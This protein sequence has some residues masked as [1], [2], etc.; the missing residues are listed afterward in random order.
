[1][2]GVS[3]AASLLGLGTVGCQIAI[4]LYTLASQISTAS[5]RISSVSNDIS[6]TAGVLK[7]LGE[8]MTRETAKGGESIFS[9]S[10]L[11]TTKNSAAICETIFNQIEQAAKE[12][13]DQLRTRDRII[14]KIKL[15]KSE[16]AKW[17]FLQP[18]I[19]S[20]RTDLREAKGT[21]MLM[22][23]VTNLAVS[24]RM[25]TIHQT[26]TTSTEEQREI[27][28]VILAIQK[29]SQ[30]DSGSRA[31][32]PS[33]DGSG[34]GT[35]RVFS[36]PPLATHT[37][38]RKTS[39]RGEEL[40]SASFPMAGQTPALDR[41]QA[42]IAMPD[43]PAP[44]ESALEASNRTP[45]L[46]SADATDKVRPNSMKSNST[47]SAL[48][49]NKTSQP[50][51]TL[52]THRE[53]RRDLSHFVIKPYILDDH[54]SP[55]AISLKFRL[56]SIPVRQ[57]QIQK[58][59]FRSE[60][61]GHQSVLDAYLDL[62]DHERVLIT[63]LIDGADSHTTLK[64]L[65]RSFNEISHRGIVFKGVPALRFIM[66]RS[67]NENQDTGDDEVT[68]E[69]AR[70]TARETVREAA[71]NAEIEAEAERRAARNADLEAG[72]L[73]IR[74]RHHFSPSPSRDGW[75]YTSSADRSIDRHRRKRRLESEQGDTI[76]TSSSMSPGEVIP[77]CG[78]YPEMSITR[79]LMMPSDDLPKPNDVLREDE[80]SD[81]SNESSIMSDDAMN[82][83]E[84]EKAVKELLE[85][86]TTLGTVGRG[87][88]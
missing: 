31:K 19:E 27:Y 48:G 1:M 41:Y 62:C 15:S 69:A 61:Y 52:D 34:E 54:S 55:G 74:H 88:G 18:S 21:L 26:T 76:S 12:A 13:S 87:S 4:K 17:P 39:L 70:E 7:E 77:R 78:M 11:E 24:Q 44:P 56:D 3:I 14:G 79:F 72:P 47:R 16:K 59:L 36:P 53:Q 9:Q 40:T 30:G 8:F 38:S 43:P 49:G 85:K 42:L 50:D 22:L 67:T 25:A 29:Q 82:D 23:Q 32:R 45:K 73:L 71:R 68:S 75:R 2:D 83:E 81:N 66:E 33:L 6:L 57:V 20:L 58:D 28:R 46:G 60:E 86:Y 65:K 80:Q 35:T 84:A 63:G 37:N 10:G 51:A 64:H 5:Q